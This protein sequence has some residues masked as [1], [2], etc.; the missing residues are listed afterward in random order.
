MNVD[1]DDA[2]LMM[3]IARAL[4]GADL[5]GL[6]LTRHDVDML[7]ILAVNIGRD[8]GVMLRTPEEIVANELPSSLN[9]L[10]EVARVR[11]GWLVQDILIL[12]RND[13][14]MAGVE[15]LESF[16]TERV[17]QALAGGPQ[18]GEKFPEEV[19]GRL[20]KYWTFDTTDF[21]DIARQVSGVF[22]DLGRP[23]GSDTAA[24]VVEAARC[25][26]IAQQRRSYGG[27][28]ITTARIVLTEHR[29]AHR[30]PTEPDLLRRD[31]EWAWAAGWSRNPVNWPDPERFALEISNAIVEQDDPHDR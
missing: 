15:D 5:T 8:K 31:V 10:G 20:V 24:D 16:V 3:K 4:D 18:L 7:G 11:P 30:Y 29:N 23:I 9:V 17:E 6:G 22:A 19:A 14:E 12:R 25:A 21:T 27:G 13:L 28:L 26:A 2:Q 1:L